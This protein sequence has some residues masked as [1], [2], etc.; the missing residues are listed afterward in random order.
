MKEM[1]VAVLFIA[2]LMGLVA[3]VASD[4]VNHFW[5]KD[6]EQLGQ[7]RSGGKVYEC[8]LKEVKK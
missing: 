5:Q 7:T 2:A 6:C 1:L 3:L 4:V 8:K